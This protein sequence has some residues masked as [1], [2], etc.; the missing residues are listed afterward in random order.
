M[1]EQML[2]LVAHLRAMQLYYHSAHHHAARVAFFAD[3][4]AFGSFY[5]E[6]EEDFDSCAER[7]IGLFGQDALNLQMLMSLVIQKL[8]AC[9]SSAAKDDSEL[10]QYGLTFENE[11]IALTDMLCKLPEVSESN[12]QLISEFGNKAHDRVYKIK[13]RIKK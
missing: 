2:K 5:A 10:F 8:Q 3:H 6:L 11:L 4:S 12:K 7:V 13:Q 9:P 1:Q